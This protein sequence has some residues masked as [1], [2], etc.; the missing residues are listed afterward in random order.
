MRSSE[1]TWSVLISEGEAPDSPESVLPKEY[2]AHSLCFHC[3]TS[4]QGLRRTSCLSL[5][6][7]TTSEGRRRQ[8]VRWCCGSPKISRLQHPGHCVAPRHHPSGSSMA[9]PPVRHHL[10]KISTA[11]SPLPGRRR[12]TPRR[13]QKNSSDSVRWCFPSPSVRAHGQRLRNSRST[14]RKAVGTPPHALPPVS[15]RRK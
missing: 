2:S 11:G 1:S 8:I 10:R 13:P 9:L 3:R 5:R 15:K 12:P 7:L 14:S 4:H 6:R